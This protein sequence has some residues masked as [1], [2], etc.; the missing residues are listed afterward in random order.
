MSR[1][2]VIPEEE[3]IIERVYGLLT[4][5]TGDESNSF[6]GESNSS[7]HDL[8][9]NMVV[10]PGKRPGH[11][12]RK[13]IGKRLGTSFI[14]PVVYSMDE[15]INF[16]VSDTDL[17]NGEAIDAIHIL[18]EL[19]IK[20][21]VLHQEFRKFDNFYS[22]GSRLFNLFEE[23]YIEGV[24]YERLRSIETLIPIP[25]KS[26][27]NIRFLSD[28]Y[29][30]FYEELPRRGLSTRSLRY[31]MAG[32]MGR[33]E[34]IKKLGRLKRLIIAGFFVFTEQE[35]RLIKNLLEE[36]S[37][38]KETVPG[39]EV[40]VPGGEVTVEAVTSTTNLPEVILLFHNGEGIADTIKAL[41]QDSRAV[42]QQSSS[43][44]QSSAL[45]GEVTVS[46]QP[47]FNLI[48]A[49]DTHGMVKAVGTLLKGF[50][51]IDERTV[52]VLP[53]AETLFPL[54]RQG[55]PYL[56]KDSYNISMGYPVQRTPIYG[57]FMSLFDAVN[58]IDNDH[59]YMPRYLKF[60]LHPYVKNIYFK[61]SA[62][63]NRKIF[64]AI[65]EAFMKKKVPTFASL[66][67]L[68]SVICNDIFSGEPDYKEKSEQLRYIHDNTIRR[69]LSFND[70]GHFIDECRKVLLFLYKESTAKRHPFFYPYVEAFIKELEKV[71]LS[72]L[73]DLVFEQRESYF[74][75][76]KKLTTGIRVPF[77]GT[78]LRGLQ[79]LGVLETRN[80]KFDRVLF[81]DLNEGV[82]PD[83]Q[84]DFLLPYQV[85]KALGLPTYQ[86][87]ERL[88][89]YYFNI[90]LSSARE[91]YLFYINNDRTER[92]RFI[93]RLLW[94]RQKSGA[95]EMPLK[96]VNY[97]VKLSTLFPEPVKKTAEIMNVI[98]NIKLSPSSLDDYL[99]CG[100]RFYYSQILR[101]KKNRDLSEDLDRS[102]I[103]NIVHRALR[104]YFSERL[105][106]PIRRDNTSAEE[107]E[108][109]IERIFRERYR[110]IFG[111]IYLLKYQIT[112]RLKEVVENMPELFSGFR[113]FAINCVE[114]PVT[115]SL[116]GITFE[117]RADAIG[118]ARDREIII[119]YKTSGD[120]DKIKISFDKLDTSDR[121]SWSKRIKSLQMPLY[122]LIYGT[123]R[124]LDMEALEGYY[125]LLGKGAINHE[126]LFEPFQ[127]TEKKE[128]L[129][130]ISRILQ[131]LVNEIRDPDT[132]FN[133][134][135][136]FSDACNNCDYVPFCGTEWAL[137]NKYSR[138]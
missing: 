67:E 74:N 20:S 16:F 21:K 95:P 99:T 63:E 59:I 5:A 56:D 122:M 110:N 37:V 69:F 121:S 58:S 8:S 77:E 65:E 124:N 89:Y 98:S 80:I 24:S 137:R 12:L 32:K 83:T 113:D 47:K 86:D 7:T 60:V 125:L 31:S 116:F 82:F 104:E 100:I 2:I 15:F 79:I 115:G 27:E 39:G 127:G 62:E 33:S 36:R 94:E 97:K 49:P 34:L 88:A 75:F 106:I 117:G 90:L 112:K 71:S 14:P 126:A 132:P 118:R 119:D 4:E 131:S 26:S 18:Y 84:E 93:E 135:D 40:T 123:T 29:R 42:E 66:E 48:S 108:K 25:V 96:S 103:G 68:E 9:Q 44:L 64:H 35:R 133:P 51:Q 23:I 101:L 136:D 55:I 120:K 22:L 28:L 11:Y 19:S 50:S 138:G 45:G 91:V 134:P 92:S 114:E 128:A 73:K 81:L 1:V 10:F 57:F 87:R 6:G 38:A 111:R 130:I 85:R 41:R 43:I 78:P 72:G 61:G 3:D 54:L 70:I 129:R 76:F 109:I 107:M 105:G 13:L 102:E 17:K 52:I 46:L 30:E 53:K